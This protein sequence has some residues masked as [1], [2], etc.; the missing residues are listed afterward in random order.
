MWKGVPCPKLYP[1]KFTDGI[2]NGASWYIV[3]GG[4]QDWNYL[5]SNCLEVTLELGCVK[6]P[7]ANKIAG[8]WDDNKVSLV[9]FI[10]QV[11]LDIHSIHTYNF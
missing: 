4:M 8:Y 7:M 11:G 2:T 6:F 10:E 3:Q 9:N 1:D 5:H